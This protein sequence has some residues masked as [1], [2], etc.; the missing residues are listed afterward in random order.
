MSLYSDLRKLHLKEW[1][2][3]YKMHYS[4]NN[5][6]DYYVETVVCDE[7]K[8]EQ[9]FINWF[10]A[11]GPRPGDD[12]V[13]NRINKLG[14]YEPGNVEWALKL[15]S[16]LNLRMHS[17]KNSLGYYAKIAQDNGI[18]KHCFYARI[19]QGWNWQDAATLPPSQIKYRK[20]IT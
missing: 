17:D 9:G 16:Q 4:C 15:D 18:R 5:N 8:G 7:W 6:L 1:R 19:R 11:L 13:L 2:I 3:W 14:D 10:D 12:Y 20:R